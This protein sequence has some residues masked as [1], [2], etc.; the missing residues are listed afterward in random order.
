MNNNS[1]ELAFSYV[2]VC[3]AKSLHSCLPLCNPIDCSPP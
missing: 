3:C 2:T 1:E